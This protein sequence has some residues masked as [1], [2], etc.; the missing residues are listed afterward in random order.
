MNTDDLID[1]LAWDLRPVKRLPN[2]AVRTLYW[3]VP[4]PVVSKFF[5]SGLG[6]PDTLLNLGIKL[7]RL[8]IIIL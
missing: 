8:E 4:L 7:Q 3:M 1:R 5:I 6:Q 2:P